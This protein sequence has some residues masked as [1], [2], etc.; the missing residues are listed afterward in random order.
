[1]SLE[2]LPQD[3]IVGL[4]REAPGKI[5]AAVAERTD[6]W[7]GQRLA[8]DEWSANEIL[9]HVRACQD[10]WGD[11]RVV[12]M[13]RED[14]PTLRAVSPRTWQKQTDYLALPFRTSLAAF[15]AQRERFLSLIS[16]LNTEEWS[17]S[18]TFTGGGKARTY[19]VHTEAD[20]LARH[21]RSHLRQ[22]ALLCNPR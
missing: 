16:D 10:I 18:A 19:T 14:H 12:R 9:A 3:K 15:V 4:L 6:E 5:T 17:R 21:E 2:L 11:V 22:L 7:L 20:A 8:P 13:L 1:M